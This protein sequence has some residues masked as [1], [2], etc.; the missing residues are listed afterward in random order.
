MTARRPRSTRDAILRGL[1]RKARLI[2]AHTHVGIDPAQYARG[3]Y[4]YGLSGEDLSLRLTAQGID[5]AVCFP[6]VYS[7]YFRFRAFCHGRFV[8]DPGGTSAF[9]YEAE[10]TGLCREIYEAFSGLAG[11]LLPFAFFDPAR[12]PAE[13]AAFLRDLAV[14]YPLFG[15]KTATSYIQSD[16]RTMLKGGACLLDLAAELDVPLAIHTAVHPADPWADVFAMLEVVRARPDVRFDLA[17]TCRF[18]RRALDAAAGLENC[19]VDLSAFHIH[20]TLAC[21]NHESVAAERHRFPADYRRHAAAMRKIADTYPDTV[22]W[23]TD[24][25]YH[26]FKSRFHDARGRV[27]RLDLACGPLTEITE[28]RKLPGALRTRIGFDNTLR[29]LGGRQ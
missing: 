22:M 8:R 14:R 23:G 21:R 19:W 25:P 5:A 15:L 17:H 16:P 26:L 12:R 11:R 20:C 7:S 18:D 13:Q 1:A 24:T 29:W 9:P 6:M 10:N 3:D 4:P 28:F 27:R 2:D